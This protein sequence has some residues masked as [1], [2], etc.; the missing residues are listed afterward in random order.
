MVIAKI[1]PENTIIPTDEMSRYKGKD[2]PSCL[3]LMNNKAPTM[4]KD[5]CCIIW[6]FSLNNE[7]SK[8]NGTCQIIT[9]VIAATNGMMTFLVVVKVALITPLQ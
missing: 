1:K 9:N 7:M 3:E 2:S 6:I 4:T 5:K 8:M